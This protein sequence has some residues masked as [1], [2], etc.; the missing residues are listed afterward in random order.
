[1]PVRPRIPTYITVHMGT[2]SSNAANVVLPF[3]YYL[4]V[5]ASAEIYPTWPTESLR[6]NVY[7]IT[8]FALN[9]IYTEHYR[10][11]GYNF[12]ITNNT[13]YDQAYVSGGNVYDSISRIVD[14]Q[15]NDYLVRGNQIQPLYAS[16]C[17]GSA[18]TCDGL[19][20]WGTVYLANE[21]YGAVRIVKNYYG[22]DV[23]VVYDAPVQGIQPSY[24]GIPLRLGSAGE[25]VRTIQRYLNRISR[26]Y[27]AIPRVTVNEGVFNADTRKAVIAFQQI[28]GLTVD[29]IVGKATWYRIREI[30][31]AV[32]RLAEIYSEGIA[33]EEVERL[34]STVLRRGSRGNEVRYVQYYL[35]FLAEFNNRLPTLSIDGIF[36]AATQAAVE[37]FQRQNGLTVDGIVGRNT[38]NALVTA[39]DNIIYSLPSEFR[40]QFYP[41]YVLTQGSTGPEVRRLQTY[42][43]TIAENDYRVPLIT[44][45]GVYGTQTANAVDAV[46]DLSGLPRTGNVGALTWNAITEL[47]SEYR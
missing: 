22:N 45:D 30:Y 7:A 31:N 34:Y 9:R 5:C 27:P 32:K 25:D 1:M 13:A 47:Y 41:G 35:D 21:G 33:L 4:K 6:A 42:L 43:R 44:V 24:P 8:S 2:P 16:Y 29:G 26:N 15:F 10:S 37:E 36:G 3:T 14:N 28:F 18:V 12:D 39:Y 38:W 46:Q 23:N 20:Q 17:S 40:E 19:S 11:R